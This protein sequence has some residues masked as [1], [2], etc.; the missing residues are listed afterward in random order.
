MKAIQTNDEVV[1][2]Y[3]SGINKNFK[4]GEIKLE[5]LPKEFDIASLKQEKPISLDHPLL[6]LI[7][8][9]DSN[10]SKNTAQNTLK[11]VKK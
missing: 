8:S 11:P 2:Q 7:L 9:K 10:K 5:K 3:E 6:P 4:W 1:S